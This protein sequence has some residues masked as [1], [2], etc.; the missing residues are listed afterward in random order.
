[1]GVG[2]FQQQLS[3]AKEN[4]LIASIEDWLEYRHLR[5]VSAKTHRV[6]TDPQAYFGVARLVQDARALAERLE[7]WKSQ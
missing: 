2:S 4:G 7:A 6:N 3:L 5:V 1:M